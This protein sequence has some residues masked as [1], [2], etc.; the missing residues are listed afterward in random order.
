ME[1]V[2]LTQALFYELSLKIGETFRKWQSYL[3]NI[4]L[5]DCPLSS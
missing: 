1:T 5:L 4:V 2:T 3:I